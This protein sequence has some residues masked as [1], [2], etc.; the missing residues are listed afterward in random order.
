MLSNLINDMLQMICDIFIKI[1]F[2]SSFCCSIVIYSVH[3]IH[4]YETN[5]IVNLFCCHNCKYL[6][7][8]N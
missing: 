4:S 5:Q 7:V 3:S 8:K 2:S 6:R 1:L